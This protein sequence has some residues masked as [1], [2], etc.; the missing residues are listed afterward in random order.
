MKTTTA[1]DLI[2]K[3]KGHVRVICGASRSSKTYSILQHL[4]LLAVNNKGNKKMRITIA[5][6]TLKHCRENAMEDFLEIL[7]NNGLYSSK[8]HNKTDSTYK[9]GNITYKFIGCEDPLTLRG[10]KSTILFVN[11]ANLVPHDSF[12]QL[13]MRTDIC[14]YIDYNPSHKSW[15]TDYIQEDKLN[16]LRLDYSHNEFISIFL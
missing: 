5:S 10:I 4:V 13:L 15:V 11:E 3:V 14:S 6:R 7:I 16:F 2:A 12:Q 1:F 9:L 8:F